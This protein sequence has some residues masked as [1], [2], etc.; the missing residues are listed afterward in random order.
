MGNAVN[1]LNTEELKIGRQ[2]R[3]MFGLLISCK[4]TISYKATRF[5]SEIQN[6]I[7]S[8]ISTSKRF[9]MIL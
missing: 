5:T 4:A 6:K 1:K 7:E 9:S 2:R 8:L 3:T